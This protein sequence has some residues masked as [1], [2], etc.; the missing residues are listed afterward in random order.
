VRNP[1]LA[2]QGVQHRRILLYRPAEALIV[3]DEVHSDDEHRYI[4]RFHFG[5]EFDAKKNRRGGVSLAGDGPEATLA[6][7]SGDSELE[8]ARGSESPRLGWTYSGDRERAEVA[9]VILRSAARRALFATALSLGDRPL[10]LDSPAVA[11]GR[12]ALERLGR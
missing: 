8:M 3:L 1:L 5:P 11:R 12:A 4:R 7:L 2:P 9:T 10:T 6:D